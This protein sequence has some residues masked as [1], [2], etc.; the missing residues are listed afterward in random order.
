M[1]NIIYKMINAVLFN[2]LLIK[3]S[4]KKMYQGFHKNIKQSSTAELDASTDF[5]IDNRSNVSWAPNQ[6]IIMISE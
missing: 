6:H 2:F 3:E 1:Y 5:N 4:W